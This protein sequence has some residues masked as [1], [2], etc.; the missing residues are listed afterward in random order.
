MTDN[1][2]TDSY[3]S[4]LCHVVTGYMTRLTNI[5]QPTLSSGQWQDILATPEENACIRQ[6]AA[7]STS[8]N[9]TRFVTVHTVDR[10]GKRGTLT[11]NCPSGGELAIADKDKRERLSPTLNPEVYWQVQKLIVAN[12]NKATAERIVRASAEWAKTDAKLSAIWRPVLK[13]AVGID[14]RFYSGRSDVLGKVEKALKRNPRSVPLTKN[15][16]RYVNWVMRS[17]LRASLLPNEDP[18]LPAI[19]FYGVDLKPFSRRQLRT[20]V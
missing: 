11:I 10:F 5:Q 4:F 13:M 20:F 17:A 18:P 6:A 19:S 2:T 14:R 1:K 12:R 15:Q 3:V 16:Q 8:C 9:L 7:Y